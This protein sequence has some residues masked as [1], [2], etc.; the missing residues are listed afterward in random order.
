V[1]LDTT[2]QTPKFPHECVPPFPPETEILFV[3][4]F[5]NLIVYKQQ[6]S[7]KITNRSNQKN[8][9]YSKYTTRLI[10]ASNDNICPN[11]LLQL[12]SYIAE[13]D[14]SVVLK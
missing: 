5:V 4:T 10:T 13:R 9:L 11:D 8:E 3:K 6:Q 14:N 1:Y 2:R 7:Q 12:V